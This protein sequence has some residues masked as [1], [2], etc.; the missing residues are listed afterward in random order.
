MY[1]NDMIRYSPWYLKDII[2]NFGWRK[3]CAVEECNNKTR[4]QFVIAS[5]IFPEI[6]RTVCGKCA[7][8]LT[9]YH[10]SKLQVVEVY[11]DKI[12]PRFNDL[13]HLHGK[14]IVDNARNR[15]VISTQKYTIGDQKI[16]ITG[17]NS[18]KYLLLINGE[19]IDPLLTKTYRNESEVINRAIEVVNRRY[20]DKLFY[21]IT[22]NTSSS[23]FEM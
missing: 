9:G 14:Q 21:I 18:G 20:I 4:S 12:K 2:I 15:N 10:H 13:R 19:S 8:Q 22:D 7:A 23:L 17:F 6:T 11:I 5:S 1:F 16:L 3:Q